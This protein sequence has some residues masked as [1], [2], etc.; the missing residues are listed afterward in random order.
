MASAAAF[1]FCDL[2]TPAAAQAERQ[3][4]ILAAFIAV[5]DPDR[6]EQLATALLAEFRSLNLI[7]AQSKES[8]ARI[9]GDG[10]GVP[11]ML[12]CAHELLQEAA[13]AELG[14]DPIGPANP[15]LLQYLMTSMGSLPDE[16]LR[17]LFLDGA[18]RLIADERL[19][20]GTIGQL[21][22]YPRPIFRRALEHNAAGLILVHNH[23]SGDPT[24]SESDLIATRALAEMARTLDIDIVE[25]IVVTNSAYR[26]IIRSPA[27]TGDATRANGHR[28]RDSAS[29]GTSSGHPRRQQALA[30]AKRALRRRLLR[31]QLLGSP[32]IFAEPAWDM[33]IELFIHECGDRPIST[34][35]LCGT[36][37]R[38]LTS[39]MRVL[40]K[41]CDAELVFR[42]G[43]PDD[44]R[45][46]YVHLAP[47]ISHRL[48]AYFSEGEG[49]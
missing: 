6:S 11:K 10:S 34:G 22:V 24:P 9:C 42:T 32:E 45:R 43:D 23:P 28:L 1:D 48:L 38:P 49:E 13:R 44:G 36:V 37:E 27:N 18:S 3:R 7:C 29:E 16:V 41:L 21:V 31:Q 20:D 17:V 46:Q 14:T 15:K 2:A 12:L 25:H 40:Q 33:L 8:L 5:T 19:Q 4:S 26:F 35:S 47:D 39:A 30:N